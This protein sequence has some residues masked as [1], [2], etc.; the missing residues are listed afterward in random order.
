MVAE[1]VEEADAARPLEVA[2]VEA[3]G[4]DV[5]EELDAAYVERLLR[6]RLERGP[7]TVA[8]AA[9]AIDAPTSA[10]RSACE[11]LRSTGAVSHME[12][13]RYVA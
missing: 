7:L 12:D 5:D 6:A 8:E 10:V 11:R 1:P 2:M 13:G 9:A 4:E 3:A